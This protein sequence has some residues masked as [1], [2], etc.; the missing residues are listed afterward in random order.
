MPC[1]ATEPVVAA[2]RREYSASRGA[3]SAGC[4][5]TPHRAP[6]ALALA[7]SRESENSPGTFSPPVAAAASPRPS[8]R[9][10]A[11]PPPAPRSPRAQGQPRAG[12]RGGAA[13]RCALE[14]SLS[15]TR[16]Y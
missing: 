12:W 14:I 9:P 8:R 6:P 16:G 11:P 10:P 5:G 1:G 3:H 7:R 4:K 2:A 13:T 15:F